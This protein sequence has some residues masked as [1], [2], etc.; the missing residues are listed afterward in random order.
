[1]GQMRK[2]VIFLYVEVIQQCLSLA[3]GFIVPGATNGWDEWGLDKIPIQN[4]E[5]V[6]SEED[7]NK[8]YLFSGFSFI[9][10]PFPHRKISPE[11]KAKCKIPYIFP[12]L[13]SKYKR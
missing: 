7:R 12:R 5:N 6:Q 11:L 1:M 3:G 4:I 8:P 13:D 9:Q 2:M 10:P